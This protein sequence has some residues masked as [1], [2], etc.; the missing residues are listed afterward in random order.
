MLLFLWLQ[1]EFRR[2][3]TQQTSLTTFRG[4]LSLLRISFP[5]DLDEIC[6]L[7]AQLCLTL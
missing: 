1:I 2:P 7:V 4:S 5:T 6:V 3:E